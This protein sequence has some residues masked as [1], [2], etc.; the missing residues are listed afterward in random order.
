MIAA[1]LDHLVGKETTLAIRAVVE[2][3]ARAADDDEW[4]VYWGLT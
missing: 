3:D 2:L 1:W 4:A